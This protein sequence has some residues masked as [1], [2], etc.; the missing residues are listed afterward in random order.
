MS[1]TGFGRGLLIVAALAVGLTGCGDGGSGK[2]EPSG[3]AL[4]TV[5]RLEGPGQY[6]PPDRLCE[7][8]DFTELAT[9]VAP[10]S[11]APR[12]RETG[13]DPAVSSGSECKQSLSGGKVHGRAVVQC[14]AWKETGKAVEM[15]RYGR[16]K[17]EEDAGGTLAEVAG[18]GSEAYRLVSGEEGPW[19]VDLRTVVRDG[20]L[21]CELMTQSGH[22]MDEQGTDIAFAAMQDVL[23]DLLPKLRVPVA[24]P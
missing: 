7:F 1:C 8:V 17:A 15:H 18:L 4:A 19:E 16:G 6:Q 24:K 3:S 9:A 22:P 21:D 20:N 12:S 13:A 10:L 5:E 11:G 14:S 2:P 23:K